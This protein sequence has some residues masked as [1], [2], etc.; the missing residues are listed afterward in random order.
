MVLGLLNRHSLLYLQKADTGSYNGSRWDTLS[1]IKQWIALL[2]P[3][4]SHV[5]FKTILFVPGMGL[6]SRK[7]EPL[8][9]SKLLFG[10]FLAVS[11]NH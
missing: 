11:I 3:K 1:N 2:N 6:I 8:F 10:G 4:P 5:I 9:S 7:I